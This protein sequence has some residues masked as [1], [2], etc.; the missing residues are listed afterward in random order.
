MDGNNDCARICNGST[1]G[2][3][4]GGCGGE[5]ILDG[6]CDCDGN[7]EDCAGVCGGDTVVGGCDETC[8]STLD[9]DECGVCD[10]DGIPDGWE[11]HYGLDPRNASDSIID[12][13]LDGWD[14]DRDGYV[15]PDT[16]VA[17]S[18]WGESF[19]NYEEY[20]IHYDSGISVTPGLRSI[21]ISNSESIFSTFDQSTDPQLVDASV[22]TIIPDNQR[23]RLIIGSKYGMTI[24]DPFNELSTLQELPAGVELKSMMKWSN[25]NGDYLVMST[26]YGVSVIE[27]QNG[28]PLI[29]SFSIGAD[30]SSVSISSVNEMVVL[31]TGS[32]NLDL[33]IFS[34]QDVW[35]ISIADLSISTPVHLDSI[36]ELLVNNAA[37]VNT[38]LHMEMD[39]RGPLL[40]IGTDGGLV[41]WNTTDGSDSTGNPWWVFN[42]EN[43]ENFVKKADLLNVSKSAIVN[44]ITPAGP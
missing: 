23:D 32:S 3:E 21:E 25:N 16:S 37:K 28:I 34:N 8:G 17:T 12:T 13:D 15:I 6:A 24:F 40:L 35:T 4:C 11:V 42:R 20:M 18:S 2:D 31:N 36:S 38:A 26:N 14:L 27:I 41:A 33:M 30:E 22:H 5:G 1:I 19:S 10:G 43:S 29:E 44:I 39:G 9:F 7:V